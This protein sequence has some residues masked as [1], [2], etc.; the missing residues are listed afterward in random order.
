[1]TSRYMF[2]GADPTERDDL[3]SEATKPVAEEARAN[4]PPEGAAMRTAASFALVLAIVCTPAS[5]AVGIR[6]PERPA[7]IDLGLH[8][9][10]PLAQIVRT[11]TSDAEAPNDAS[12]ATAQL[13]LDHLRGEGINP[14]RAVADPEGGVA[15]YVFGDE[16]LPGGARARYAR[17]AAMNDGSIVAVCADRREDRQD[18]WLVTRGGVDAAV[19]R[20][21]KWVEV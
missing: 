9:D 14:E 3:L 11:V 18:G 8:D 2:C 16:V 6:A 21:R 1:M 19:A 20:I 4:R 7:V 17:L 10:D 15:L 13:L 12:R 5:A